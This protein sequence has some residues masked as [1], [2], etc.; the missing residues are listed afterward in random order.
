MKGSRIS[1]G[2]SGIAGIA[3]ILALIGAW[4][5]GDGGAFLGFS[6]EHLFID[7]ISLLLVSIAS[8]VLTLIHQ[9]EER[10]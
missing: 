10:M 4:I 1:H 5:A 2:F 7:A 9:Q 8:G 6:Q 3:G